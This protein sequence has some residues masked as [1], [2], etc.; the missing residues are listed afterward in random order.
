MKNNL[1]GAW[2]LKSFLINDENNNDVKWQ[3]NLNG[4]LIYTEN[5]FMSASLNGEIQNEFYSGKYE[6]IDDIVVHHVKFAS[7]KDKIN[8]RL[9]RKIN[10]SK[11]KINL[12]LT[13]KSYCP[14]NISKV[15]WE[16]IID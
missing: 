12:Q 1:V 5:G 14:G 6:I 13:A 8:N 4:L 15:F 11:D 9:E 3:N 10:L 2:K 16:K 7:D